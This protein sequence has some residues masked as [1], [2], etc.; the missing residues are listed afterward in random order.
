MPSIAKV[1]NSAMYYYKGYGFETFPY[2]LLLK[3]AQCH[4][5]GLV[6]EQLP[7][8]REVVG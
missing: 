6:V 5:G 1:A 7:G 4:C 3:S 8:V 2:N